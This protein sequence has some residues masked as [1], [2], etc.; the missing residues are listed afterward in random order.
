M[1]L[2]LWLDI[3]MNR[4]SILHPSLLSTGVFFVN[5]RIFGDPLSSESSWQQTLCSFLPV[6]LFS[7]FPPPVLKQMATA[8]SKRKKWAEKLTFSLNGGGMGH[9]DAVVTMQGRL[10][11][12]LSP[13]P[14][15]TRFM[16]SRIPSY[17]SNWCTLWGFIWDWGLCCWAYQCGAS[18]TYNM[19]QEVTKIM[20]L[21]V[22]DISYKST[23]S[24]IFM[25]VFMQISC[26]LV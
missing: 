18:M 23:T 13:F 3:Q 24:H 9:G 7:Y 15:K 21:L 2:A 22:C 16:T 19:Q 5:Y 20:L 12:F 25:R 8:G 17:F 14:P 4:E 11:L 6:D 10:W 26:F 1:S